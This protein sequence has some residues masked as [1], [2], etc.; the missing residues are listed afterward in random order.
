MKQTCAIITFWVACLLLPGWA[1]AH[2]YDLN[3]E[4]FTTLEAIIDDLKQVRVIFIGEYHDQ[5]AHHSA[6]L[7][8][9]QALHEAGEEL[10]IGV[11]MFRR[12]GQKDLNRWVAGEVEE[13]DFQQIFNQHWSM[14]EMYREIFNYAREQQIPLVGLNLPREIIRQVAQDGFDSLSAEQRAQLPLASCNVS[15]E[16]RDFIRRAMG[17]HD[18]NGAAFENF[19][20]AQMLWDASMAKNLQEYLD[21]RPE[22]KVV[23]LAGKGHSWKH[24]IPEQLLRRG[25]YSYRVLLPEVPGRVDLQTIDAEDADYLLQGV[26]LAPLH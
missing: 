6:Q 22:R 24:G 5:A 4:D 15:P 25:D 10:S 26:E 2:S 20:A 17:G 1:Q 13:T 18:E 14:W 12:N 19:C 8:L 11:E 16:Y 23:V 3:Q 7:Q 21:Q 9:I